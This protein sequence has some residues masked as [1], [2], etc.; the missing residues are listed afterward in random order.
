MDFSKDFKSFA[1]KRNLSKNKKEVNFENFKINLNSPKIK[2]F[3]NF[4]F[5]F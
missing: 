1:I 4:K 5:F 3:K 2:E